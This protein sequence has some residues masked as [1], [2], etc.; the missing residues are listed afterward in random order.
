MKIGKV[1]SQLFLS[2]NCPVCNSADTFLVKGERTSWVR[3]Y[4]CNNCKSLFEFNEGDKMGGQ[5]DEIT[6]LKDNQ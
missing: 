1:I 4:E 5:F 2:T 6:I 3:E